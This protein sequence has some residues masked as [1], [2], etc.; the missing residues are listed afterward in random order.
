MIQNGQGK[1]QVMSTYREGDRVGKFIIRGLIAVGGMGELYRAWDPDL[2]RPVAI[3]TLLPTARSIATDPMFFQRFR[4]EAKAIANLEH[5]NIVR[6]LHFGET[7]EH[8]QPYIVMPL[9]SG[10]DLSQRLLS[11]RRAGATLP[12]EEA[13][14]IVLGACRGVNACHLA[15]IVHRDLKPANVFLTRDQESGRLVIKVLD[16]GVA[17]PTRRDYQET[18]LDGLVIGTPHYMSPEQARAMPAHAR[19][20]QYSLAAI[21]YA[22]LTLHSPY[23]YVTVGLGT[24]EETISARLRALRE[25]RAVQPIAQ[26]NPNT[27]NLLEAVIFRA[28]SFDPDHRYSSVY[29]FGK[30]LLPYASAENRDYLSSYYRAAPL[31]ILLPQMSAAVEADVGQAK[32][33]PPPTDERAPSVAL[34]NQIKIIKGSESKK[35]TIALRPDGVP[36]TLEPPGSSLLRTA[37]SSSAGLDEGT[38]TEVRAPSASL[39]VT[40]SSASAPTVP[41]P[42]PSSAVSAS[43]PLSPGFS[44][45]IALAPPKS[46]RLPLVLAAAVGL[47]TTASLVAVMRRPRETFAASPPA[48]LAPHQGAPAAPPPSVA[49]VRRAPESSPP[50]GT[51][52]AALGANGGDDTSAPAKSAPPK[53][54]IPS[55]MP[56]AE[57]APSPTVT[58]PRKRRRL[59]KPV[60]LGTDGIPILH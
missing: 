1:R 34:P 21:L 29:E 49:G 4:E 22:M 37:M 32:P 55:V 56:Q 17:R 59:P 3:K 52:S 48:F 15:G 9:L 5:E 25:G 51:A 6:V 31:P 43:G 39:F 10:E 53:Q 57:S 26:Y 60:Q 12:M 8:H 33:I 36:T 50:S 38:P 27:P 18:T 45:S 23:D 19:S 24:P 54:R 58:P 40:A 16:F 13:L 41:S 42:Q 20:D 11:A 44:G 28:M 35:V 46:S 14:E 2:S 47:I 30:A 7:E